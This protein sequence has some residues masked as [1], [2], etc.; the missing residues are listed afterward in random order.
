[1]RKFLFT[2]LFIVPML[3]VAQYYNP[4]GSHQ[5]QQ[6]MNQ[7]AYEWGRRM[8][9][10]QMA[11]YE[12]QLKQNPLMMSGVA[13]SEMAAGQYEKAYKHFEYLAENYNDGNAWLYI[14]YMNELGMG[15]SQSYNYAKVCYEQ[16]AKLGEPNCKAELQRIKQGRYLGSECKARLRNYFQD[17]VAMSTPSVNFNNSGYGN[18]NG[19]SYGSSRGTNSDRLTCPTCHGSQ[20]CTMCAGNGWYLYN[21]THYG[22]NMCKGRGTCY[23]CY[24]RG[25]IR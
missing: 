8:M 5:Q 3:S 9:E 15:T 22:C 25:W 7:Q 11:Q 1:M 19:G 2:L 12:Q 13:V 21:G 10:Q 20:K 6:Q 18:H 17:I 23:G 14:G 24:G 16:G 4:Y